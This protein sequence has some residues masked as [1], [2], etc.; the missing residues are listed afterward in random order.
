MDVI[1]HQAVSEYSEPTGRGLAGE[2]VEV[3][4][5]VPIGM[6]DGLAVVTALGT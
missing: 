4:G 5:P 1:R 6:E 2:D 3:E